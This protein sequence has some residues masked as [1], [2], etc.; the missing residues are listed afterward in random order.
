MTAGIKKVFQTPLSEVSSSDKEGIGTLRFEG[1]KLYKY[2]KILNTTATVAGV[3]GDIVAYGAATGAEDNTVVLDRDD[4]DTNP[5]GAGALVGTVTGT[6]GTAEYGWIQVKGHITLSTA[7]GG[8]AGDGDMLM[9]GATDKA[10][11]KLT[12]TDGTPNVIKGA[13]IGIAND[14][15]AKKVILDCPF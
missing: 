7:V 4:A 5:I 3:A 2:V 15:T 14:A 10:V 1:S 11:E 8:S 12:F 9:A 6:A 13:Y